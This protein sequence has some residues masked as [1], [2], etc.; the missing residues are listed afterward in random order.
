[1]S[2]GFHLLQDLATCFL[3]DLAVSWQFGIEIEHK[4]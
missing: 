3:A 2:H 1:M 4:F